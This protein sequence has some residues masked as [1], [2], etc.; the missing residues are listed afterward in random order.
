M[1][2][3]QL[4]HRES[5]RDIE[6]AL[7]ALPGWAYHLGLRS[8][9]SRSTLGDANERRDWRTYADFAQ[10]L[11][12]IDRRLYAEDALASELEETVYA[13]DSTT[14]DLCLSLFPWAPFQ[15]SKAALKLH[16]LLDLRGNIPTVMRISD[17]RTSEVSTLD[18][19]KP[20]A[21]NF[22]VMDRGYLDF[23]RLHRLHQTGA[24]FVIRAWKN[25]RCRRRYS[26]AV[27]LST[28]L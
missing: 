12:G 25:L 11:I 24:Y 20:E 17:G 26:H 14:I 19:I 4:T 18:Q 6:I 23:K 5:L 16:T 2:S 7:R 15:K 8:Q 27:D 28:G 21:G 13:L 22:Y 9:V 10:V 3:A 1:A